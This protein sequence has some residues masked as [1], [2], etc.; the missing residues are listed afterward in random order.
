MKILL[1]AHPFSER[2]DRCIAGARVLSEKKYKRDLLV[3]NEG[4]DIKLPNI[5]TYR[6]PISE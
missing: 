5:S 3:Y 4:I 2:A 6:I 1:M